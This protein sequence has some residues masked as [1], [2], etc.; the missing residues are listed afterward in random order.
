MKELS[1][2]EREPLGEICLLDLIFK[3]IAVSD[4]VCGKVISILYKENTIFST[5]KSII[6]TTQ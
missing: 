6:L 3:V 5:Y 2:H 1:T 4:G